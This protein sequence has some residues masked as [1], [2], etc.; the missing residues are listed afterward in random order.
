[1]AAAPGSLIAGYRVVA[2]LGSGA[3]GDVYIVENPHLLRREAM[4]VISV[5]GSA[6]RDFQQRFTNEARTAAAL[7]HPSIITVHAYGVD[8]DS[9]WFTMSHLDGPDLASVR[10]SAAEVVTAVGQVA[11]ALDYAHARQ[12][13][14]RDVKPANIVITRDEQGTLRRAVVLDFGIARL[15]DSPQ[16]TAANSVVGTM[17]YTAPEIISGN[18]ADARSDQYSLACTTY[19]LLAGTPPFQGE[20]SA[21]IMMAHLQHPVPSIAHVRPDLAPL[22]PVLERAMAKDPAAR[23]PDCRSFAA[24]LARALGQTSSGTATA[25]APVPPMGGPGYSSHPSAPGYGS[26]PSA[27]GYQSQPST[28]GPQSTP[29]YAGQPPGYPG[30][31]LHPGAPGHPGAPQGWAPMAAM[32]GQPGQPGA[33]KKSRKGLWIALAAAAVAVIAVAATSPLWWPS[34]EPPPVVPTAADQAELASYMGSVCAV[35]GGELYCWGNNSDG[36]LGDGSQNTRATPAKV[37]NLTG[38]TAVSL[39]GYSSSSSPAAVTAC[40]VADGDAYCWGSGLFGAVGNGD[41]A[42]VQ[43]PA[44]V[45]GLGTVT[46]IS[47]DKYTTCAISDGDVYCWGWNSRGEGGGPAERQELETPT[48]VDGISQVTSLQV[49]SGNTCAVTEEKTAFCWGDNYNGQLGNGSNDRGTNRPLE[50]SA[51]EDVSSISVGAGTVADVAFTQ[52]CAVADGEVYCWGA[53]L[54]ADSDSPEPQK[55]PKKVE[56]ITGTAYTVST[57]VDTACAT[58]GDDVYCWGNDRLAQAG[59]SASADVL[60]PPRQITGLGKV[61]AVMTGTS[62]TCARSD[63]DV[64]CWGFNKDGRVG[65]GSATEKVTAP[66]KA[67]LPG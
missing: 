59:G 16:L 14:H 31:P 7:D 62:T 44:K 21:A 43:A 25:V 22:A 2:Q 46:G 28:A 48:K 51:L 40:A 20:T 19:T 8:G 18:H 9:P 42:R 29:F 49:R 60:R 53:D 64:Y 37:P 3:M 5:G 1:M 45:N 30:A 38:V 47:T 66:V 35:D 17:A 15:A 23:Y 54:T 56:G 50:V 63:D 55:T 32:P 11:D 33:P 34:A 6:N 39:G 65:D 67:V 36:Q 41:N 57:D 61:T 24:E 10:L 12:V 26:Q 58:A 27:P 4:K 52:V 13:V